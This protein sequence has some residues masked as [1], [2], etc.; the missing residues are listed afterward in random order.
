MSHESTC[1]HSGVCTGTDTEKNRGCA[2]QGKRGGRVRMVTHSAFGPSKAFTD[3]RR[4]TS[5]LPG[6]LTPESDWPADPPGADRP[7]RHPQGAQRSRGRSS[8]LR[9]KQPRPRCVEWGI[10]AEAHNITNCLRKPKLQSLQTLKHVYNGVLL[11][12]L[13]LALLASAGKVLQMYALGM[14][15]CY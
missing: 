3:S 9:N 2:L 1:D 11:P 5:S 6:L 15:E 14:G 13:W 10:K 7:A 4:L 8:A 12:T